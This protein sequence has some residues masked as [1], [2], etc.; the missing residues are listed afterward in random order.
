[1]SWISKSSGSVIT[2]V[3][4]KT[5]IVCKKVTQPRPKKF[6]FGSSYRDIVQILKKTET[7]HYLTSD[8]DTQS[9]D[10]YYDHFDEHWVKDP[11]LEEEWENSLLHNKNLT[12][13]CSSNDEMSRPRQTRDDHIVSVKPHHKHNKMR[14]L[15]KSN[16]CY[17]IKKK[18]NISISS[19]IKRTIFY[20]L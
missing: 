5:N 10:S 14:Q 19:L 8:S 3:S 16:S 1:M 17:R 4:F 11:E 13:T 7:D 2:T 6:E 12:L 15:L 9:T 20:K 18:L